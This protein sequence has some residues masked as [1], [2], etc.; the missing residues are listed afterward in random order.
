MLSKLLGALR[1]NERETG[2]FMW[3]NALALDII[4]FFGYCN[5]N[6]FEAMRIASEATQGIY[7]KVFREAY[8]GSS[9]GEAPEKK[10]LKIAREMGIDPSYRLLLRRA[11]SARP[12]NLESEK[13]SSELYIQGEVLRLK[14]EIHKLE[15]KL[16]IYIFA[17]ILVPV[18][19]VIC[20]LMIKPVEGIPLMLTLPILH[21]IA[22]SI[23]L[24]E[25]R[26]GEL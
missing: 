21:V 6:P 14:R 11:L 26:V 25:L 5:H 4:E 12:R 8:A 7:S 3:R 2:R 17:T 16:V 23:I 10:L 24:R 22:S 15:S 20:L 18:C 19:A 9:R 13:P 1:K